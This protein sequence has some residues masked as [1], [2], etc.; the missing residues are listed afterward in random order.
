MVAAAEATRILNQLAEQ[1]G[2]REKEW[3][4]FDA[5]YR[6]EHKLQFA[7]P[8]FSAY[9]AHRYAD[10]SDNWTQVV[11]DAPTERLELIGVRPYGTRRRA[12]DDKLWRDWIENEADYYSDLAW[13]DAIIARRAFSLVWGT[14]DDE[15]EV[16]WENPSQAIVGYDPG[17]R[18]RKAGA[19]IW[20]DESKEFGT[21]YL[22][23]GLYKFERP[24]VLPNG[25]T[26]SGL[27]IPGGVGGWRPREVEGEPWPLPNPLGEVPLV[28]HENRARLIGDP[29]SDVQGTIAMQNAINL[30]WSYLFNAADFASFPQ[31]VVLGSERPKTPI[32]DDQGQ[33]IGERDIPLEK[34]A[35]DRVLFFEGENAKIDTWP[36][37]KLTAYTEVV[38]IAVGHIAAQ[39]RTPAH[40]LLI[41]KGPSNVSGDALKALETGLVKRTGEKTKQFGR[42]AREVF[43]LMAKVRGDEKK[44]RA[45][46]A[47]TVLWRD[48]ES[49]SDAQHVDALQKRKD[50]GYP[51]EWLAEQDGL[52]PTEIKRLMEMRRR[53]AEIDPLALMERRDQNPDEPG[54]DDDGDQ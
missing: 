9:M 34:F 13:L 5:Q 12:G 29:I 20:R 4:H 45:V 43:R 41:G 44:A 14:D 37:A 26:G 40:Y 46:A 8:E 33:V 25:A 47:G 2:K 27:I 28:E 3:K 54:G 19:K 10:F 49:R 53:E 17:T 22:P 32:L 35:V 31:R 15:P 7:S 16:S 11:A 24:A 51:F 38:E 50:M 36:E 21:L 6:G 42:S 48:V 52:S 23:D 30:L 18:R 39:T 1:L